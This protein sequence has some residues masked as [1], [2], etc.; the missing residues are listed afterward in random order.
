MTLTN[1]QELLH[2]ALLESTI[3]REQYSEAI[4]KLNDSINDYAALFMIL[5]AYLDIACN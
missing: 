2:D 1:I 5:D 3:T 4:A